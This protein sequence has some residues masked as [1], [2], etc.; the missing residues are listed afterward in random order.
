MA[1]SEFVGAQVLPDV[2][3]EIEFRCIGRQF[4]KRDVIQHPW[5]FC[6]MPSRYIHDQQGMRV[7]GHGS[8]E[9]CEVQIHRF[10]IDAWP[11][12]PGVYNCI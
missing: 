11:V 4:Q 12:I 5:I 7:G 8:G 3:H 1:S 6:V 2:F 9:L 10:G